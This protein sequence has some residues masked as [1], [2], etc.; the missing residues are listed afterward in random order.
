MTKTLDT[1]TEVWY[2]GITSGRGFFF[3]AP[4]VTVMTQKRNSA[5]R[6]RYKSV[7][8]VRPKIFKE[9]PINES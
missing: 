1:K 9:V 6:G 5:D 3:C 8:L 2:N 4:A 7:R